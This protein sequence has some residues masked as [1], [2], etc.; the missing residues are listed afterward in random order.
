MRCQV[1]VAHGL[2]SGGSGPTTDIELWQDAEA[3]RKA[4]APAASRS[5]ARVPPRRRHRARTPPPTP[6]A[7]CPKVEPD[8]E[9]IGKIIIILLK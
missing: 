3:A 7:D 1:L 6:V 2:L 8:V 5:V 4:L 9:E